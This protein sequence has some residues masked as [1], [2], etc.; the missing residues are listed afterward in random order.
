MSITKRLIAVPVCILL[1][2]LAVSA[3]DGDASNPCASLTP[4]ALQQV[5]DVIAQSR[6]KAQSDMAANGVTGAYAVAAEYNLAYLQDAYDKTLALQSWLQTNG[7]DSPY[8]TNVSAAYSVHGYVRE[9][10]VSLQ[11]ARHWAMIS[12]VYHSSADARNSYELTSQALNLIEPLGAQAGR[13]YMK[14]YY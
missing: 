9:A 2:A 8:V 11:Y 5:I 6:T 1:S 3:E 12:V 7:L 10:V 4:A 14:A 13:C